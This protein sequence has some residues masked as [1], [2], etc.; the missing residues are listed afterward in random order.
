MGK[1]QQDELRRLEEAL[2]EET[3]QE[4]W[5]SF[6]RATQTW[7]SV[8]VPDYKGGNTDRTHVDMDAYSEEVYRGNSRSRL[9][10]LFTM[11]AM[12]ALSACILILLKFLGVL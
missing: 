11:L 12:I 6:S 5:D 4:N 8:S 3:E 1:K 2:M 10:I 9:G 7:Q